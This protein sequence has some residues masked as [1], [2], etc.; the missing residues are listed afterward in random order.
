MIELR[1]VDP[2]DLAD[3]PEHWLQCGWKHV[4]TMPD[5]RVVI[6]CSQPGPGWIAGRGR[7]RY[8]QCPPWVRRYIEGKEHRWAGERT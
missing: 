8:D 3:P 4:G 7:N 5:G 1:V 2:A 6:D